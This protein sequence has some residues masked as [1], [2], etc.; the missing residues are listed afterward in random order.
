MQQTRFT[1]VFNTR[2]M[3]FDDDLSFMPP[4]RRVDRLRETRPDDKLVISCFVLSGCQ[5]KVEM[6]TKSE[7][8]EK[9]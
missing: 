9:I 6:F 1:H 5:Q 8:D 3:R 2:L 4:D 7:V